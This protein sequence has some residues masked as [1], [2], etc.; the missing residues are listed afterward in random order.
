M[1]RCNFIIQFQEECPR[2][3][4]RANDAD[5][6]RTKNPD[7]G[8]MKRTLRVQGAG[9]RDFLCDAGGEGK[10]RA[11]LSLSLASFASVSASVEI[12]ADSREGLLRV[13]W[14]FDGRPRFFGVV[15]SPILLNFS[16]GLMLLVRRF[17]LGR[18]SSSSL[19][20]PRVRRPRLLSGAA[21][22]FAALEYCDTT[23]RWNASS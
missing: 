13:I 23:C 11:P 17:F 20:P 1:S 14:S 19:A 3:V 5:Q 18:S 2:R 21:S 6:R 9:T 8:E 12:V 16:G 22:S 7:A 10:A 4:Y 15:G